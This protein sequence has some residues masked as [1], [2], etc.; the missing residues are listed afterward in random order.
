MTVK[1]IYNN[2]FGGFGISKVCA[3][4][5]AERGHEGAIDLL[6]HDREWQEDENDS[7]HGWS[8]GSFSCDRHDPM[9]V[10]AVEV[11]GDIANGDVSELKVCTLMHGNRYMIDQ[12]DGMEN[13]VEPEDIRW[14]YVTTRATRAD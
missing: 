11:L 13:V 14:T 3:E 12:Y 5:M 9:L 4:W 10:E 7:Y 8:S 6:K 1:V 2:C